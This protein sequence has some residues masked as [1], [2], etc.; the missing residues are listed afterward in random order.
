MIRKITI[1]TL[2][3]VAGTAAVAGP[4]RP[5]L[6]E[7][8]SRVISAEMPNAPPGMQ[9]MLK[10]HPQLHKMCITPEQADRD[11]RELFK[12]NKGRCKY[13]KF[14]MTGGRISALM[15]CMAETGGTMTIATEG[16]FSPQSYAIKSMMV[17]KG[18]R[19]SM[20]M[21]TESIGR[22]VGDCK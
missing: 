10:A 7:V 22:R 6:W 20:K 9:N 19:G 1:A 13:A 17:S 5:G 2:V 3:T 16:S 8:N 4:I 12:Q 11:P 14:A 15:T 18:A 21:N